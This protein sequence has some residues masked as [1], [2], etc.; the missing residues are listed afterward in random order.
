MAVQQWNGIKGVAR[1]EHE[2]LKNLPEFP[3]ADEHRLSQQLTVL[4]YA[5]D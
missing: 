5:H 2:F 3:A 1:N 4:I